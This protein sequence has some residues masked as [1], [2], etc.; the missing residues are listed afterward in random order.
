MKLNEFDKSYAT[1]MGVSVNDATRYR[2][3]FIETMKHGLINDGEVLIRGAFKADMFH[4]KATMRRLPNGVLVDVPSKKRIRILP[5]K[6]IKDLN[7]IID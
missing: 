4:T 7:D 3:G 1:R 6:G 5:L 2:K